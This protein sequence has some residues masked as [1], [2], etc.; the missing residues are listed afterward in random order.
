MIRGKAQAAFDFVFGLYQMQIDALH[1]DTSLSP[2]QKDAGLL[3]LRQKQKQAAKAAQRRIMQ[4]EKNRVRALK[5]RDSG[6]PQHG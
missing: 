6:E 5:E 2:E 3:A 1:E 4:E